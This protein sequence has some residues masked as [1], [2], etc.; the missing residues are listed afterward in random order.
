MRAPTAL[1]RQSLG[2]SLDSPSD[3]SIIAVAR[4]FLASHRPAASLGSGNRCFRSRLSEVFTRFGARRSNRSPYSASPRRPVTKIASPA[5][6][7]LRKM[8][9]PR[10]HSPTT[11]ILTRIS[12]RRVVSPPARGQ[13]SA[14]EALFSP[15]RNCSSHAPVRV[16]GRAKLSRKQRG[17]APIAVT[18]LDARTRL[19]HPIDSGG[20]LFRRK[21]VPSR[22]QSQVN[23][24]SC[25]ARGRHTAASSPI[26]T[27]RDWLGEPATPVAH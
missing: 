11:V 25:P 7:P 9:R 19:F 6:A 27:C 12:L 23:I 22:N 24:V 26:A 2:R 4:P 8:A 16:E 18:S 17:C 21:C 20:C 1:A 10:L 14:R 3:R 15:S 13:C 5:R